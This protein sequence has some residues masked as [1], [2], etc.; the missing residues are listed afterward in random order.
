MSPEDTIRFRS[1]FENQIKEL[2]ISQAE[3]KDDLQIQ[4]D[5]LMDETDMTSTALEQSMWMRLRSREAL[6]VKKMN[7]ALNRIKDGTF[8][9]CESCDEDIELRRLHARPTTTFCMSCKEEQERR[10]ISHADSRKHK[11]IGRK[12]NLR[13]A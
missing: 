1:L 9:V 4:K 7:D 13:I 5:D 11:S 8:G 6:F 3:V 10:E 12:F 2:T